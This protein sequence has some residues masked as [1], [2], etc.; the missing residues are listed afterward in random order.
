MMSAA[1][2]IDDTGPALHD[3]RERQ[4]WHRFLPDRNLIDREAL[5][6]FYLPYATALAGGLYRGR[7]YDDV[8]YKD[9]VQ[10]ACVGLLEA[11]DRFE[12]DRNIEF[13]T[14]ATPRIKGNVLDG[15]VRLSD[16]Q[17]QI[18]LRARIRRE[19]FES[20]HDAADR[21]A[22]D[23]FHSLASL[24]MG[25]AI[26]FILDD[27]GMIDHAAQTSRPL[28]DHAYH[29]LAWTQTKARL[30]NAVAQLPDRE[31]KIVQY[32]YFHGLTFER[33][34]D[35]LDLSKGRV[36]QLH[37]TALAQLRKHAQVSDDP[38]LIT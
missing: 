38:F 37:R 27:T 35:I 10:L 5:F 6:D 1:H 22:K 18:A 21:R 3:G 33:I 20:L 31:R 24:T 4:L 14:F 16:A 15:I 36:S 29:A 12:A 8:E 2:S 23:V 34:G 30:A 32:H 17:E 13:R 28:H 11:I 7:H 26:G 9:Y 25:L 19:R